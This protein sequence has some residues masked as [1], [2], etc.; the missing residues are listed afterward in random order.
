MTMTMSGQL[1]GEDLELLGEIR[2]SKVFYSRGTFRMMR[3]GSEDVSH[4]VQRLRALKLVRL[5]ELD[6]RRRV[7]PSR[8]CELTEQGEAVLSA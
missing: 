5:V 1:S 2:N 3:A 8:L 7:P 4:Q 6:S